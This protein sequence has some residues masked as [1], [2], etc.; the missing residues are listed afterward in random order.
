MILFLLP[1]LAVAYLFLVGFMF[2]F[3]RKITNEQP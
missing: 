1:Y 3:A 2:R